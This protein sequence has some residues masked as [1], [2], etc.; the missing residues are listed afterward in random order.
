MSNLMAALASLMGHLVPVYHA[1]TTE[2]KEAIYRFRYDIY[3]KEM[4][5]YQENADHE[6]GWLKDDEDDAPYSLLLY[7]GLPDDIT[8]TARVCIWDAGQIPEE[9]QRRLSTHLVPGIE[10]YKTAE[11]TRLMI[12]PHARGRFILPSLIV[13]GYEY[14]AGEAKTDLAFFQSVPALVPHFR[15]LGTR[16]YGGV[17]LDGGA[18]TLIPS[19]MVLSDYQYFR[20]CGSFLAPLVK[21]FF[22]GP[23]KRKPI[24]TTELE[25]IFQDN[26]VPVELDAL[27]VWDD[28]QADLLKDNENIPNFLDKLDASIVEEI[29][30]AGMILNVPAG[31]ILTKEGT[32]DRQMY[33][34]LDGR[35]EVLVQGASV[36]VLMKGELFGEMAFFR[37]EGKR[38]ATV[39]SLNNAK[40]LVISQRSLRKLAQKTPEG[41]LQILTNIGQIMADR[42]A[43]MMMKV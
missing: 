24:D 5:R 42:L 20:Q 36:A 35:F 10:A 37:R 40:V 32:V 3:V 28:V 14:L 16:P 23:N 4:Q 22:F 27:R 21:K 19:M 25:N 41:A 12:K 15:R 31:S 9:A 6:R 17:L 7:C 34:I 18:S 2:E 43:G 1:N 30:K 39:K 38:T 29:A 13:N 11:V 26:V 33:L 8:A